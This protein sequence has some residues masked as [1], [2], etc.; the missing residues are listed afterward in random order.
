MTDLQQPDHQQND[1]SPVYFWKT[2]PANPGYLSQW[3]PSPFTDPTHPTAT[4]ANA[5]QY[6]MFSKAA[7]FAP[8]SPIT[9]QILSTTDPRKLKSLG[10]KVHNFREV[11]WDEHKYAIV[12]RGNWLKFTQNEQLKEWLLET[13]E[14]EVVEASPLDRVW[15]I[16][17]AEDRAGSVSRELWGENLLGKAVMEVR[18][19]VREGR[20]IAEVVFS[21]VEKEV[22]GKLS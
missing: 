12:R 14:R 5:E 13:G 6:M 18:S 22:E 10:R 17:F 1:T 11:V 19:A 2:N 9:K 8:D 7:L 15:G 16:G 20:E 4:F 3:Y 21:E